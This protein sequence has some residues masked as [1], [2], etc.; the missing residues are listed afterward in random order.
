ML[1]MNTNLFIRY[2][3]QSLATWIALVSKAPAFTIEEGWTAGT[4]TVI[5][6][7]SFTCPDVA[8]VQMN[9]TCH[10]IFAQS[11]TKWLS[12]TGTIFV[13]AL[14]NEVRNSMLDLVTC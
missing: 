7:P 4:S 11:Q 8:T 5:F 2:S 14:L 1:Q 12:C 10:Y 13:P 3:L 9:G 6:V